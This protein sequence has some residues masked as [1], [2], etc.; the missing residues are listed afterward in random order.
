M[1]IHFLP[2]VICAVLAMVV[3]AVWYGPIFGKTWM[4]IVG[5]THLDAHKRR[6]MQKKAG[7]LYLIQFALAFFQIYV[8]AHLTGYSAVSGIVSGLLVWAGFVLPTVAA[9]AMWNND[10]KKVAWSRF[11]IQAGYQLVC[12]ILFGAILGAWH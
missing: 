7:P 8:L 1:G 2:I 11:L 9:G 4:H 10:S 6:E 3:G 5:A 12:F